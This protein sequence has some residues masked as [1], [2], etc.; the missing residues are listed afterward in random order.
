M[1]YSLVWLP[2]QGTPTLAQCRE[3]WVYTS[4]LLRLS[5]CVFALMQNPSVL[6]PLQAE[7]AGSEDC[8]L[9]SGRKF[10]ENAHF[11]GLKTRNRHAL[12]AQCVKLVE[13]PTSLCFCLG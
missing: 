4:C 9:E 13:T 6:D 12:R 8:C 5:S 11:Q 10:F 2:D 1:E 7:V 3:S